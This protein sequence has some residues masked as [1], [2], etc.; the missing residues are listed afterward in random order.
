MAKPLLCTRCL[1]SA[2]PRTEVR[3]SIWVEI[4][5]WLFMIVP[6]LIYSTWRLTTKRKVCPACGG[7][8]LIPTSSPRARSLTRSGA[9]G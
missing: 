1:T 4:V 7:P 6:G 9:D 3:G 8:D 5:L 2:R